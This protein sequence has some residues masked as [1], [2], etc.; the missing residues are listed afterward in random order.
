MA[1]FFFHLHECGTVTLD[2]DGLEHADLA[3]ARDE[4]VRSA[5][6]V[7]AA[8]VLSGHLCLSCYIE[9]ADENGDKLLVIPF[10]QAVQVTGY[11]H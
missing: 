8:E 7:M 6:D 1:R 4:A 9:V 5:R 11:R 2:E 10:D 3:D